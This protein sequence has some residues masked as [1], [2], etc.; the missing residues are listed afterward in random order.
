MKMKKPKYTDIEPSEGQ[1]L[2]SRA[3][4]LFLDAIR[5]NAYEVLEDLSRI[6]FFPPSVNCVKSVVLRDWASRWNLNA[7]W[8]LKIA[9][10]T[11]LFWQKFPFSVEDSFEFLVSDI[12]ERR[13]ELTIPIEVIEM[14]EALRKTENSKIRFAWSSVLSTQFIKAN[15]PYKIERN[16][17]WSFSFVSWKVDL[18]KIRCIQPPVGLPHWDA[19]TEPRAFY[20]EQAKKNIEEELKEGLF[21]DISQ[22]S[23]FSVKEAKLKVAQKYCDDI[24]DA[25]LD[26]KDSN[27]MSL[28]EPI[29]KKANLKRNAVWAV[30]FQVCGD[31]Y[32]EI[33]IEEEIEHTT[34][35]R[36]VKD[37]LGLI[38][39]KE[40]QNP[41]G[42]R[43]G[44]TLK[45]IREK[46]FERSHKN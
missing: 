26:L 4:S 30:K 44:Q 8:I 13:D 10:E 46:R 42:R 15:I 9:C 18:E 29:Q 12:W 25:Y 3:R 17:Y 19:D 35:S 11:N 40:R 33:A 23:K 31:D 38:G 43:K 36:A 2:I 37:F 28:W 39:L 41:P 21:S 7:D 32:S 1:F 45:K 27:K 14:L 5:E 20:L 24:L 22:D 6:R 16:L 34:V